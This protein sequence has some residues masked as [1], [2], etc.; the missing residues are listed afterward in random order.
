MMTGEIN[1]PIA[2][3]PDCGPHQLSLQT[4]KRLMPSRKQT[5][6]P[7]YNVGN[8]AFFVGDSREASVNLFPLGYSTKGEF[9]NVR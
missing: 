4:N 8:K 1:R 7:T 6:Q 9:E 2:L 5:R 3:T